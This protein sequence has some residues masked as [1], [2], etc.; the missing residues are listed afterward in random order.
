LFIQVR[1]LE[2]RIKIDDL[3]EALTSIFSAYGTIIDL[4]AKRNIK[5]RGQ[6]FV[7]FDK[8]EAAQEAINE[9]QGF[10][11][12]EKPMVLEFAKT[13]S[14]ATV[15][16]SGSEQDFESHKSHRVAEKGTR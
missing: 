1:N 7:V 3:K 8:P 14:D 15:K 10:E 11:L 6:A 16:L 4:V 5:A 12:F 13:R 9:V 2:E